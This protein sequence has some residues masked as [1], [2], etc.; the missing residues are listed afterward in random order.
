M[1]VR[2]ILAVAL[3]GALLAVSQPAIQSATRERTASAIADEVDRFAERAQSLIDTDDAVTSPG[4]RR[5]VTVTL[6][7]R[8]RTAAG[9][10]AVTFDPDPTLDSRGDASGAS[11]IAWTVEGGQRN[12][13]VL[14]SI[15]L[16]TTDGD[17]LSLAEPGR[18][19]LVLSLRGSNAN[20]RVHVSRYQGGDRDG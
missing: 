16:E 5:I 13:R 2:T 15:R 7:E 19:R 17:P 1:I 11:A 6:P 10:Q 4:A 18:H 9:V 3:A 14:E 20:P 12:R 8:S